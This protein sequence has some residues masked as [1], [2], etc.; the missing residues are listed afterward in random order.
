MIS[1]PDREAVDLHMAVLRPGLQGVRRLRR[2]PD[3]LTAD[4]LGGRSA[5]LAAGRCH[6]VVIRET[7]GD[8]RDTENPGGSSRRWAQR[9]SNPRRSAAPLW[10]SWAASGSASSR[11]TTPRFGRCSRS[12]R[13]DPR[14]GPPADQDGHIGR[15]DRHIGGQAPV[16]ARVPWHGQTRHARLRHPRRDHHCCHPGGVRLR[17]LH[18]ATWSTRTSV[19]HRC[20]RRHPCSAVIGTSESDPHRFG[21]T[22]VASGCRPDLVRC[23]RPCQ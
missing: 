7:R 17:P 5:V 11:S 1:R 23:V 16:R 15:P 18:A 13:E 4:R 21:A 10:S 9:D 8:R 20:G 3:P 2:T 6:A 22:T 19:G 12:R 14:R